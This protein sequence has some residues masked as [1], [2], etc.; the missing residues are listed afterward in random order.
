MSASVT[1]QVLAYKALGWKLMPLHRPVNGVCSCGNPNCASVGKHPALSGWRQQGGAYAPEITLQH[2]NTLRRW[3]EGKERNVAILTGRISGIVALDI[4][5]EEGERSAKSRGIPEDGPQVVTGKGRHLYFAYPFERTGEGHGLKNFVR[6]VQGVDFRG[7]GGYVAAPPSLHASGREYRWVE[8]SLGL[9]LPSCPDWLF[10]LAYKPDEERKTDGAS[11]AFS[12]FPNAGGEKFPEGERNNRMFR[13]LARLRA[14]S[15]LS[16][17][18]LYETAVMFNQSRCNPPLADAEVEKIVRQVCRYPVGTSRSCNAPLPGSRDISHVKTPS[19][20]EQP[21]TQTKIS[22]ETIASMLSTFEPEKSD[23]PEFIAGLFRKG[24]PSL[25]VAE[26]GLGKTILVQ[27]LICDLSIGG[28]IWDGFS[29]GPPKNILLFCG[30]AGLAMLNERLESSGWKF[31][32]ERIKILDSRTAWKGGLYPA[33]DTG[34]GREVFRSFIGTVKPDLVVIDSLGSFAEDESGREAMKSVFDFLLSTGDGYGC[35]HLLVHHLRKRK[36][37]ERSLPLDMSEV[38]GSSVITRHS[39][40][41][42]GMEKCSKR[43]PISTDSSRNEIIVRPLKTWDKPFSPFS[44]TIDNEEAD[45]EERLTISFNLSPTI[46]DDKQTRV[47]NAIRENFS[48]GAEFRKSDIGP[49]C[50]GISSNY[51]RK[52]LTEWTDLNRIERLGSNRDTRY[53]LAASLM[54]GE[55]PLTSANPHPVDATD[56]EPG[57]EAFPCESSVSAMDEGH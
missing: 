21:Q 44:F 17:R 1:E 45:G 9:A 12:K 28:P 29:S 18:E 34:E 5:S 39:A 38:I 19:T 32:R 49:L 52:L 41:V 25:L 11:S 14:S 36:N 47:W 4:D 7:D 24:Y 43:D 50:G 16:D 3:F 31:D 35:A 22:S 23:R 51:I 26:P 10:E 42:I 20:P 33:L 6:A 8:N 30:E 40:L 13:E 46:G 15:R 56:A 48:D 54:E 37:N 27:R 57:K 53:R 2:P 55:L